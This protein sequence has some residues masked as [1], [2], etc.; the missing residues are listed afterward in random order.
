MITLCKKLI[1][2]EIKG[3]PFTMRSFGKEAFMANYG[4]ASIVYNEQVRK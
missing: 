2:G 3:E 4:Q 1:A